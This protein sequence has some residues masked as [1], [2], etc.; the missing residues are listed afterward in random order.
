MISSKEINKIL[1]ECDYS[2]FYFLRNNHF[3]NIIYHIFDDGDSRFK[4]ESIE[5]KKRLFTYHHYPINR[6]YIKLLNIII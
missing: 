3:N 5:D 1:E 4:N 6:G 2:D